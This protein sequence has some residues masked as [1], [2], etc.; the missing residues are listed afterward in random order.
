MVGITTPT[1]KLTKENILNNARELVPYLQ[2]RSEEIDDLRRIPDDVIATLK[3]AG[4]FRMMMPQEW[5]GPEM[6]PMEV[7][8]VL[9]VLAGGNAS[10]AWCVMIQ[11]DSGQYSGLLPETTARE[12]YSHLDV[13][14]SNVVQ[15]R[16]TATQS[17]GGY[18]VSGLWPFASGC[19]HTDWFAGGCKV[20]NPAG[21]V[22]KNAS[23]E[24]QHRMVLLRKSDYK[25]LDTWYTT[26]LKGTGSNDIE[27]HNVFVPHAH[28]FSFNLYD[29]QPRKGALYLW[30]AILNTKM[31]GV[32]LGIARSAIEIVSAMLR[33]KK[34][35]EGGLMLA[36]A[37]AQTLYASAK[38][39]VEASLAALWDKLC[40]S[41]FPSIDERI[42]VF[43][44]RTNAFHASRQ[45]VQLM[46]DATGGQAI[47]SRKNELDRHLRDINTACQHILAQRKAQQAAAELKLGVQTSPFPFL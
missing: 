8:N 40:R 36:V 17:E 37:D 13:T 29:S 26:G 24:E 34:I 16:G 23:G 1:V 6:N 31:P 46:Y 25:V 28:T 14:T 32:P 2:S 12:L 27:A 41:E 35:R 3:K 43:L 7:N 30:P 5:G 11:N 4:V 21:A 47:Y 33:E 42:A 10:V 44:S 39:Y 18:I 38:T 22:I 15:A 9:E 19:T 45:A 20:L